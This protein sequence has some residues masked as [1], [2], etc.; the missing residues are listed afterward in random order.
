ML[1][2]RSYCENR[3]LVITVK[4]GKLDGHGV[5]ASVMLSNI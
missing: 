4:F 2:Y 3:K 5:I 1:R